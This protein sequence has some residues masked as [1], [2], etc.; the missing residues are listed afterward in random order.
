MHGSRGAVLVA[1]VLL[2]LGGVVGPAMAAPSTA[3]SP[4]AVARPTMDAA[5]PT[6]GDA[7]LVGQQPA[8]ENASN[9]TAGNHPPDPP[10]DVIGWE[11][12][13]WYNETLGFNQSGGLTPAELNATVART[14]ARVEYLRHLEF[15]HTVPVEIKSRQWYQ[16]QTANHT[17]SATLRTFDNAKFEALFLVGEDQNSI[18]VQNQNSGS[19][20]LGYYS[21]SEQAIVI[22]SDNPS[23]LQLNEVT[24][25]HELTHALQDQ[26]FN[27]SRYDARTRDQVNGQNGL[28]EGDA[29]LI[30]GRYRERCD[31]GG[32]WNGTCLVPSASFGGG[33]GG[34][35]SLANIGVY[36]M[37]Y[38]P[39]SDGPAFVTALYRRGGWAAVD[40]AY[41]NPPDSAE[42]VMDPQR[43]PGDQPVNV[44][45]ADTQRSGWTRVRPPNRPDYATLGESA[46][47]AMLVYPLYDSSGQA[48]IISPSHWLNT[49]ADGSLSTFDPLNYSNKYVD[50]WK[51]DSLHVYRNDANQTAYVWKLV[52]D[53]P[54]DAQQFLDGYRQVLQYWGGHQ[55]RPGVWVIQ[56][57]KFADAF[58]IR[59]DGNAVTIVN[60]P[61]VAD[62]PDVRAGAATTPTATPSPTATAV[63]TTTGDDPTAATT[64][65]T[66]T[67]SGQPGFGALAA[68]VCLL[69][70][71]VA[72]RR[73]N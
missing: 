20:V 16:E 25:A 45:F 69:V 31:A 60:A 37:K 18:T 1:L 70:G 63:A 33:G 8:A 56:N 13:Y 44:T 32:A 61:T 47:T 55:V 62:L 26:H 34:G 73:W 4:A 59:V 21:P 28:I 22:I 30:E 40:A 46:L 2:G 65:A 72:W 35:G 24:L 27:L 19:D 52:W 53:T 41:A 68:L 49:T 50:G 3:P 29:H 23:T 42:Q 9:A 48:Q 36:I 38:Q 57:G 11:N 66:T 17:V 67:T 58:A 71:A 10:H 12:G 5:N 43:Y 64:V 6:T 39:Y 54:T 15:N 51:G 7:P 14:E